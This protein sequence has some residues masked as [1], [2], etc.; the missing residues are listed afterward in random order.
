MLKL[1]LR[2]AGFVLPLLLGWLILECWSTRFPTS[3]AVKRENLQKL[4]DGIDTLI[5]G[6]S[7]AYWD[8]APGELPGSA[9]NLANVAQT[10]YYDDQL[11][12]QVLPK[13]PRLRRVILSVAYVSLYFQLHGT[14]EEERQYYY[15]QEWGIAPPRLRDRLDIRMF[16]KV[17]LRRPVP[18]LESFAA[19][20]RT[21]VRGGSLTPAP[22]D[23][24]VDERGWCP[25][26]PGNPDDLQAGVVEAKLQYHHGLMHPADF[27]VNVAYLEHLIGILKPRHIE[28]ILVTTPVWKTYSSNLRADYAD[29]MQA[30]LTALS[31]HE[32]VRYLSF[33][34]APQFSAEEFLDADH[35]NRIG[36]LRFTKLLGT[37]VGP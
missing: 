10:F 27:P 29:Q 35:L 28:L 1:G 31:R 24:P 15:Y 3:H 6:S 7:N 22:L 25:R 23:P 30:T 20:L 34:T 12:A 32:N 8:I 13:L 4:A 11:V 36:A 16:S 26:E 37:A 5:I 33:L 18:V 14:D 17:A 2:L 21:R 9:F 19:A